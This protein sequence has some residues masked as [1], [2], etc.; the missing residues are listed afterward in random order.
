MAT[1]ITPDFE[2]QTLARLQTLT[3]NPAAGFRD[4]QLEAIHDL[5]A[6]RARVLCVQR[7]GWG[8]SGVYFVATSLLR[9]QGAGP[10][11]IVSPLLALMRNQIAGAER[12]G[13]RART[14]NSTNRD[15]WDEIRAGLAGDSVDLLLISPERL[16]NPRFRD[17]MLPLFASSVGL[18]VIDEAHC[19]SDWGHD[20]RP[21]YRR[22]KDML[23][24]LPPQ[25]AVLG[26]TATANDRV[27]S[28]VLEQLG[29]GVGAGEGAAGN[30]AE[31]LRSYRGPLGRSSLR[32]ETLELPRPAERLAWL[33]ERLPQLP[34]SGIVYTLTKRDAEQVASFL[35]ANGI[36]ALAYS[37][38]Q[39]TERR[40][41]AEERLLRNEVK[42]LVATS[43][44]G[45]GYD[46][47]DL[48]FVVHYQAPGSVVSYYQQVGRAGRG[49]ESAEVVLL[50]GSEDR[51]IQDFFIEQAFP[52]REKVEAVLEELRVASASG[53]GRT[54]RELMAV[55]NL[56]AG[57]I[58]AM[59]KILDVEGAVMR[60]GTRW[61]AV[62]GSEWT[63]DGD[64]Y[65]QIT[66]LRRE[67]QA[68]MAAFGVDGR[69]LM[70]VLQEE[71]DDP[72]PA[73]CGRCSVCAGP[74]YAAPPSA[75]LV[76]QAQRHL[77]SRP[78]VLEQRK[79]APDPGGTMR[80]I[81]VDAL[82]EPGWALA[83]F[84]DGGWWPAIERGL[85]AGQVDDE[86]VAGLVEALKRG[87]ARPAWV[88][89][90]PSAAHG[91]AVDRLSEAVAQQL[92]VP[93][94]RLL[95]RCDARPPQREMANAAQQAANVRGA[96]AVV[97]Q[98]PA[99]VGVLVD[100]RRLSGFT[101]AMTGGQLRRAGAEAVVPLT[102][103][104]LG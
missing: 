51:R 11:L 31:A 71:L 40:I 33:V 13:L 86:V 20:F 54:S 92:G 18:L 87:G 101:L 35:V 70:R 69:C 73:D 29:V 23:S 16:N 50:R 90:V 46:K 8:K 85:N 49:V 26:T 72:A 91:A 28:D 37:G 6:D 83:R 99:G 94:L 30:D 25:V 89:S 24:A 103:A 84:G 12:L 27:V 39:E 22:V 93:C 43:A 82:V 36:S 14:I 19:I 80:K 5:V 66:A 65:A 44:L 17:E 97:G 56:G 64:R 68:A 59:L 53:S 104:T 47:A 7:T 41:E 34:G 81:P 79:M 9:A 75:A 58:E 98:P 61:R 38:E 62:E 52:A 88:T 76:E 95:E 60:D 96:F 63:Y 102:L 42:A 57:R 3:G 45:M 4:G 48:E 55:V 100:D 32:L 1:T 2:A 67:E 77:R 78:I 74:R 21:D 10:T 15:D